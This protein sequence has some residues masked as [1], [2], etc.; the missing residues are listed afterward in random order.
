MIFVRGFQ[1]KKI[2]EEMESGTGDEKRLKA[3]YDEQRAIGADSAE[4]RARRI[5]AVSTCK[6]S[7]Q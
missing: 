2:L 7:Q 4:P 6:S 1:E 5:L 3:V